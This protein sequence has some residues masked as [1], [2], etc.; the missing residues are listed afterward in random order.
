[1]QH[2]E[3]FLAVVNEAKTRVCEVS[4]D[5][6]IERMEHGAQLIDVREDHEW[7]I[8]TRPALF[9]SARA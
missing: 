8:V 7:M 9:I 6:A 5:D 1:M 3:E 2:S 4:V